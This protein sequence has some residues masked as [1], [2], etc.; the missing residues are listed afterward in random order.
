MPGGLRSAGE[1]NRNGAGKGARS[2]P[3]ARLPGTVGATRD[4]GRRSAEPTLQ[5]LDMFTPIVEL[6]RLLFS[7]PYVP[8]R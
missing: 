2:R 7:P 8:P 1:A 3:L 6:A 4:G 5:G